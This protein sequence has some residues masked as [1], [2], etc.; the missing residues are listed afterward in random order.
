MLRRLLLSITALGALACS[1]DPY[2]RFEAAQ[3][4]VAAIVCP[5]SPFGMP[6]ECEARSAA[7]VACERG[8]Y[9]AFPDELRPSYECGANAVEAYAACLSDFGEACDWEIYESCTE[10]LN[11]SARACPPFPA[12]VRDMLASCD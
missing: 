8:N 10:A 11:A 2:G 3:A 7:F 6:A 5:C 4:E 12:E 9:E 1:P